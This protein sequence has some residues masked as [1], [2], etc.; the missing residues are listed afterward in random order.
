MTITDTTDRSQTERI[1]LVFELLH[2]PSK[3]WRALTQADLLGQW[4]LPT[5]GHDLKEGA[6]FKLNAPAQPGWDGIV[7]CRY[8]VITPE[9]F[10]SWTWEVPGLE[11]VVEVTLTPTNTGTRMKV[12]QS[13][14]KPTQ[15]QNFGGARWGWKMMGQ[16]L[17]EL[18]EQLS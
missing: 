4:L 18:L 8:L 11:T 14:F 6:A 2:A 3:V 17:T 16:R 5:I 9:S 13:G 15:K 10:V 1:E 7:D 12:V